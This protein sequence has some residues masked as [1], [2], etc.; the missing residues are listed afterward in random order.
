MDL[1]W[2]SVGYVDRQLKYR[3]HALGALLTALLF[4]TASLAATDVIGPAPAQGYYPHSNTSAVPCLQMSGYVPCINQNNANLLLNPS[5]EVDQPNEGASVTVSTGTPGTIVNSVDGWKA[6]VTSGPTGTNAIQRLSSSPPTGFANYIRFTTGTAAAVVA[7]TYVKIYQ[8]I[9]ASNLTNLGFGTSNASMMCLSWVSQSSIASYYYSVSIQ[10]AALTRSYV[11]P[12]SESGTA[13]TWMNHAICF[14]GDQSGTWVTTGNAEG[15]RVNFVLESGSTFQT[16][17]GNP[18]VWQTNVGG[19]LGSNNAT[20]T[21]LTTGATYSVTGTKLEFI[22]N[23]WAL[24]PTAF[25]RNPLGLD[26]INA[27]RYY[28]KT[29]PQ[30]TKPAQNG[31]L[32]GCLSVLAPNTAS[33]GFGVFWPFPAV[34]RANPSVT[35]YDP[36]AADTNWR[37]I[38]AS[39]STIASAVDTSTAS[40]SPNGVMIRSTTTGA[41]AIG[42][43][44]C[45]HATADARL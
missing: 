35:A 21:A 1:G 24:A 37:D 4:S 10:N 14:D 29:F 30:G 13:S 45:I 5:M 28:A 18:R 12:V 44:M 6:Q 41:N 17:N 20:P 40:I 23:G 22:P 42:D 9:E 38:T 26:L 43:N 16:T 2:L 7:G 33:G 34:M 39:T 25:T 19:Y 8:P 27:Q 15:M 32:A 31:G 11:A 36:L 3:P